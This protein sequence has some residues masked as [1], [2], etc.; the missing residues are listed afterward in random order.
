[1]IE[2]VISPPFHREPWPIRC[3]GDD[4]AATNAKAKT[5][6]FDIGHTPDPG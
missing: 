4:N 1:V 5:T 6:L 2:A 3:V